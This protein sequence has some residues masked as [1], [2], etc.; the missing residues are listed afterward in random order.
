MEYKESPL[1]SR[2]AELDPARYYEATPERRRLQEERAAIRARLKLEYQ[3][4]LNNP[5]RKTLVADPAVDRW[6]FA[7]I[8]NIYPNFRPTGKVSL[9]GLGW[10]FGPLLLM[11]AIVNWDRT[12]NEKLRKEGKYERPFYLGF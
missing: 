11:Y 6:M 2:P 12:N 1:V 9:L 8:H 4:Q 5:R 7:R 10:T 3:M